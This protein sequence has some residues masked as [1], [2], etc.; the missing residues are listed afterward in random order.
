MFDSARG[1]GEVKVPVSP[2]PPEVLAVQKYIDRMARDWGFSRQ[3]PNLYGLMGACGS[4]KTVQSIPS[5]YDLIYQRIKGAQSQ[6]SATISGQPSPSFGRSL[7][8]ALLAQRDVYIGG[9]KG[10]A[11]AQLRSSEGKLPSKEGYIDQQTRNYELINTVNN[12]N[13][14]GPQINRNQMEELRKTRNDICYFKDGHLSDDEFLEF[15]RTVR[16]W[17]GEISDLQG[18]TEEL[19]RTQEGFLFHFL[20]NQ[21]EA[22]R[23]IGTNKFPKAMIEPLRKDFRRRPEFNQNP[24]LFELYCQALKDGYALFDVSKLIDAIREDTVPGERVNQFE[25][26]IKKL[27][28]GQLPGNQ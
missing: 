12:E 24:P 20:T 5:E 26:R 25:E 15:C 7:P 28:K 22:L 8:E 10:E 21:R 17:P 1:F 16:D 6:I 27:P 3:L 19:I 4:L 23:V 9:K 14:H 2:L 11:N 13:P 18:L